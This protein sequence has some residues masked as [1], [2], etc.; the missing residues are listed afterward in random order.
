M[1]LSGFHIIIPNPVRNGLFQ[2][3]G[4]RLIW[5]NKIF[6][7]I[8][9][10]KSQDSKMNYESLPLEFNVLRFKKYVEIFDLQV[11]FSCEDSF[12]LC[13]Y[14]LLSIALKILLQDIHP[15]VVTIILIEDTL[16]RLTG[17]TRSHNNLYWFSIK[18]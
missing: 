17:N 18:L 11:L 15:I 12:L 1:Y 7:K 6:L 8:Q 16:T 9:M 10:Q 5:A 3:F 2:C 13:S 4:E 14:Q